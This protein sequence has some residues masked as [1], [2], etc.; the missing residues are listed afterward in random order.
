MEGGS[1]K[2]WGS[3][4]G[5]ETEWELTSLRTKLRKEKQNLELTHCPRPWDFC[6]N[7]GFVGR[8][9]AP[10][11]ERHVVEIIEERQNLEESYWVE[12]WNNS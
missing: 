12:G 4:A 3:L 6:Q 5:G 2:V 10:N 9:A 1:A 8:Q 7:V 11:L